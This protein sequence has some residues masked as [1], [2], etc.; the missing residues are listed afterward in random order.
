MPKPVSSKKS[1]TSQCYETHMLF[2]SNMRKC[3]LNFSLILMTAFQHYWNTYCLLSKCSPKS[4]LES[5]IYNLGPLLP[6]TLHWS[7]LELLNKWFSDIPLMWR[8][9]PFVKKQNTQVSTVKTSYFFFL[10]LTQYLPR[11]SAQR[12]LK[13]S[14][15]Y[16]QL[17]GY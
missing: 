3:Y 15:M 11:S 17:A 10:S 12:P 5:S 1:Q 9:V 13:V 14:L 16:A 4:P 6:K 2:H 8:W 7:F